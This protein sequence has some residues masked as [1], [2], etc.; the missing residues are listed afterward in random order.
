MPS[1]R[2][3]IKMTPEDMRT[4]IG[5]ART[6]IIVSNGANGYPHP[7]PM[8]FAVDDDNCLYVTTFRKSQKVKN[9]ERDA[10]ATLLIEAGER[11]E[12][13]R[14]V[15]IYARAEIIDDPG[16][17]RRVAVLREEKDSQLGFPA[18][19]V[20]PEHQ[21]GTTTKRVVLKFTPERFVSWDHRK[22]G[23]IY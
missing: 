9:F 16:M 19:P 10:R 13:L 18:A 8:H 22:L 23:G 7:M 1:R 20:S 6:L 17:A 4:F 3:Q 11:Y 15:L 5:T 2:D 12:E 14:A 21:P